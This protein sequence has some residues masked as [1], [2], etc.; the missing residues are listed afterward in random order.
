[1]MLVGTRIS[2]GATR[3]SKH[4]LYGEK[5]EVGYG[6]G[7]VNYKPSYTTI[8]NDY[9]HVDVPSVLSAYRKDSAMTTS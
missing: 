9:K 2:V 6:S 3:I 7:R 5:P 8:T 1:M 4:L